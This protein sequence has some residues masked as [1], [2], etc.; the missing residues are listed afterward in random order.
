MYWYIPMDHTDAHVQDVYIGPT[1]FVLSS[2][3]A[4]HKTEG[5]PTSHPFHQASLFSHTRAVCKYNTTMFQIFHLS[6]RWIAD[7]N[8]Y[9]Q[10]LTMIKGIPVFR[11]AFF[12]MYLEHTTSFS[13]LSSLFEHSYLIKMNLHIENSPVLFWSSISISPVYFYYCMQSD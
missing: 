1:C 4:H 3:T 12:N 7:A 2:L 13:F 6:C 10:F 5:S 9:F 11:D 8:K